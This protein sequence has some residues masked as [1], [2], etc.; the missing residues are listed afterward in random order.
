[1]LHLEMSEGKEQMA[2]RFQLAKDMPVGTAQ[3]LWFTE[4]YQGKGHLLVGDSAFVSVKTA[5][6]LKKRGVFFIGP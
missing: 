5:A 4:R 6:E 1:M 2:K 3:C